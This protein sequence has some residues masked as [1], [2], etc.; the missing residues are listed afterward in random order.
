MRKLWTLP[1][2]NK[3]QASILLFVIVTIISCSTPPQKY[4]RLFKAEKYT[5]LEP[6]VEVVWEPVYI[7]IDSRTLSVI[8]KDSIQWYKRIKPRPYNNEHYKG[9]LYMDS[10]FY[11]FEIYKE[12]WMVINKA[13]SNSQPPYI[14]S[15]KKYVI[16]EYLSK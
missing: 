15:T 3:R 12:M 9:M 7:H 11:T 8:Y 6:Y 10:N 14:H 2:L 13:K 1:W 5:V 16:Y 4:S